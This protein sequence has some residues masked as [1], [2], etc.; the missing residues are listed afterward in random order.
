MLHLISVNASGQCQLQSGRAHCLLEEVGGKAAGAARPSAEPSN[1]FC[2]FT[3]SLQPKQR[4]RWLH[5]RTRTSGRMTRD[6]NDFFVYW[7]QHQA[8]GRAAEKKDLTETDARSERLR[9]TDCRPNHAQNTP[10]H[11]HSLHHVL[12]GTS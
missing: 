2:S 5:A 8:V 6:N 3:G 12:Q 11:A 1:A 10:V 7:Q 9:T 4:L